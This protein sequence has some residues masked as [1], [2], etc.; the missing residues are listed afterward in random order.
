MVNDLQRIIGEVA[1]IRGEF[2]GVTNLTVLQDPWF[3]VVLETLH[4]RLHFYG[5]GDTIVILL[6][7]FSLIPRRISGLETVETG[8]TI[9]F[10]L[11]PHN[12]SF[13]GVEPFG[14]PYCSFVHPDTDSRI[15]DICPSVR[16]NV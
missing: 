9:P 2:E 6:I 1:W 10:S 4:V 7:R 5:T 11:A 15:F 3:K 8:S 14:H 13:C 12:R 16:G